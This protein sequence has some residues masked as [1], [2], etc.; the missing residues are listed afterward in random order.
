MNS[1]L[2]TVEEL[3]VRLNLPGQVTALLQK[4]VS[5]GYDYLATGNCS[6][7][8]GLRGTS[9]A[10]IALHSLGRNTGLHVKQ[11]TGSAAIETAVALNLFPALGIDDQPKSVVELAVATGADLHC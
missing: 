11:A 10:V 1:K 3:A 4:V 7:R 2:L 9:L 8:Q 5:S 6:K